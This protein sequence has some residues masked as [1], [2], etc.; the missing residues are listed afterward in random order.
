[1]IPIAAAGQTPAGT[2]PATV[3]QKVVTATASVRGRVV[4]SNGVPV[5]SAEVRL[6]ATDGRD[7]RVTTT[8]VS[9]QYEIRDVTP[10][11]WN[12]RASKPGFVSQSS[13]QTSPLDQDR[14][15]AIANGQRLGADLV[16]S[17]AGAISGRVVDAAGD[18]LSEVQVMALR[19]RTIKGRR[20]LTSAGV[21]DLTDDTG[22]FR[23]YGLPPGSYY[24]G[25]V[26]GRPRIGTDVVGMLA[27][28]PEFMLDEIAFYYPGTH[29]IEVAQTIELT[30]GEEQPGISLTAP[31]AV[32]GVTVSG[33][34]INASGLPAE[35]PMVH[36]TPR[37][38]VTTGS[39]TQGLTGTDAAGRFTVRNVP[40]GE[41]VV[42]AE[43]SSGT[44]TG[45]EYGTLRISVGSSNLDNLVVTTTRARALRGVL[46]SDSS[47]PLPTGF[48]A[49]IT[50]ESPERTMGGMTRIEMPLAGEFPIP[51]IIGV[52]GIRI[53]NLP[54]GWMVRSI[55]V[56]G[57]DIASGTFDFSA[58]PASAT[59]RIVVTNRV[60]ELTGQIQTRTRQR[61]ATVVVFP[62][63]ES[64]WRYPA[65][66]VSIGRSDEEGRY[67]V[68]GLLANSEY[69]AVAVSYLESEE[70]QDP[71]F[72]TKMR[73]AA[74]RFELRDGE[75]KTLDLPL[76][77]R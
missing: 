23:L 64:K 5:R 19:V 42:D 24:V 28:A 74:V 43:L 67:V 51:G 56:G 18:P 61:Q 55:E 30:A 36:V 58:V 38:S 26:A 50:I 47:T 13:S 44:P 63:D 25:A 41:Y 70:A 62:D 39:V 22:S 20:Q 11:Q 9:G 12:L 17:R 73:S 48:R 6:N 76:V 68:S 2:P 15:I 4:D 71:A 60:G 8:D 21:P 40:P 1:M 16:L 53:E 31:P 14:P 54:T 33:R 49:A 57:Q 66:L 65:R 3:G 34:V 72:L 35:R 7:H 59:V 32:K 75:K 29:D 69:R 10:G 52:H 77:Q 45:A 27:K 46:V 37:G